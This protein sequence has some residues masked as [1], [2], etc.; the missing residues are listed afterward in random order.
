M[1]TTT[2]HAVAPAPASVVPGGRDD[3]D[4]DK[5]TICLEP[6]ENAGQ[7]VTL[8]CGHA[9]HGQCCA[10]HFWMGR[11]N[12]PICRAAPRR[13]SDDDED[14]S[15]SEL[16][17][18]FEPNPLWNRALRKSL[19]AK[20]RRTAKKD[21]HIASR[22]ATIGKW[23]KMATACFRLSKEANEKLKPHETAL[24]TKITAMEKRLNDQFDK[25]HCGLLNQHMTA[26][27]QARMARGRARQSRYN[28]LEDVRP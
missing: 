9:F 25:K 26:D 15:R 6:Y 12:C 22:L 8:P 1:T 18:D 20:A 28:L 24:N 27:K 16:I 17:D 23:D 19:I 21:R 11:T 5:C 13:L 14:D 10:N 3:P 4:E 2:R 7:R